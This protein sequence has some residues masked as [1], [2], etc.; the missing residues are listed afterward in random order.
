AGP[1]AKTLP[2]A[3]NERIALAVAEENGCGY[4]LSAHTAI[5]GMIGVSESE[6]AFSREG[7]SSDPKGA[8]ALQ[9]ARAGDAERGNVSD[10]DIAQVRAAGYDD[11][12]IAAIVAHVA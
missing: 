10:D 1:P 6:L 8:A 7:R 12:D 2:P 4:C 5:R 11:A 9:F 3:L